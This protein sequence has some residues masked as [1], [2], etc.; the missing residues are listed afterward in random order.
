MPTSISLGLEAF[1]D[2]PKNGDV[3]TPLGVPRF[4]VLNA[5]FIFA[6]T[7]RFDAPLRLLPIRDAFEVLKPTLRY[8]GP[9][10]V[11]RRIPGGRSFVMPS[12][13]SSRPV[14]ML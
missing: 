6:N 4:T 7:L 12:P 13:L 10:L 3:I 8:V 9:I 11:S 14:V 5:L 2:F 1:V